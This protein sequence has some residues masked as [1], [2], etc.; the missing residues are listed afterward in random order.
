MGTGGI[1]QPSVLG[2]L[3]S[4]CFNVFNIALLGSLMQPMSNVM[5]GSSLPSSGLG[6]SIVPHTNYATNSISNTTFTNPLVSNPSRILGRFFYKLLVIIK[7][8]SLL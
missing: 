3:S 1:G 2:K 4:C 7:M 5:G 8:Y 6:T